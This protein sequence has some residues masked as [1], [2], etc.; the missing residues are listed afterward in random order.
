MRVFEVSMLRKTF[1]S[2]REA[3]TGSWRKLP[4][5]E[6]DDLCFSP[7]IIRMI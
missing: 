1:G 4:N 3:V 2:K 7:N 5:E 6:L